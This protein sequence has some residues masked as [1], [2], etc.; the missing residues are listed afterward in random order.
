MI[1]MPARLLETAHST[2]GLSLRMDV[3]ANPYAPVPE[4]RDRG[5]LAIDSCPPAGRL[6]AILTARI[7]RYHRVSPESVV[8]AGGIN[9]LL[10]ALFQQ[11]RSIGP[12]VVCPS[13]SEQAGRLGM[14]AGCELLSIPHAAMPDH[15]PGPRLTYCMSPG[16]PTGAQLRLQE[17][18]SIARASSY[19][20][21]DERHS[22]YTARDHL[23]LHREFD[24][25]IL[26][27]TLE[28]W[29]GLTELPV[30]Y[31]IASPAIVSSLRRHQLAHPIDS[32][33]LL[34]GIASFEDARYLSAAARRVAQERVELIRSLRKL[35]MLRP[36][37]S[38]ANFVLARLE[39][40]NRADLRAFL[41]ARGIIVHYPESPGF[42]NAI[43]ISAISTSATR[44]LTEALIDWAKAL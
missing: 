22:A 16:D 37:P 31:T 18:V 5:M 3:L 7:A 25:V 40:G 24:N 32:S 10:L 9:P 15:H 13:S 11:F 17:A 23:P 12:L 28:T 30:A 33:S 36:F 34:A 2:P 44:N 20:I 38:A 14:E 27:R 8:T 43:R 42:E 6:D 19:L 41:E 21:V 39:R 4:L 29:G 26:V 1:A 35:N